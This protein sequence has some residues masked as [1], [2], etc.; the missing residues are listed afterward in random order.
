MT[1]RLSGL[2]EETFDHLFRCSK[3]NSKVKEMLDNR[4]DP[5]WIYGDNIKQIKLVAL[6][7]EKFFE[8]QRGNLK[9]I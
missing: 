1:C 2:E 3:Y 8:N 9:K 5:K 6:S 7:V 4:F